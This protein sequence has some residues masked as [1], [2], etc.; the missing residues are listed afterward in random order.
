M[1]NVVTAQDLPTDNPYKTK[2][3]ATNYPLWTDEIRWENVYDIHDFEVAGETSW[4][5]A[6]VVAMDSISAQN[7]GVIYFSEG[8][9]N[10][11]EN[12]KIPDG[13]VIRGKLPDNNDAKQDNFAPSTRFVF[14]KYEPTFTGEG[15][16]NSTAFKSITNSGRENI[17]L[18]YLDINRGRI[19]FGGDHNILIF[20]I[21]QNNIAQPQTDIP[22]KYDYMHGWQRF[23][24]RHC[25]NVGLYVSKNGSMVNC[26]INDLE[27]NTVHPIEDDSYD[28]PGYIAGCEFTYNGDGLPNGTK[29]CDTSAAI[30]DGSMA[31]FDYLAHYAISVKGYTIDP[32]SLELPIN[33]NI[34]VIDN[35]IYNTMRVGI[36][37]EAI[38]LTVRGNVRKDKEDK[39]VFLHP[40]GYKLND[41]N[42]ATFENRAMNFGGENIIIED[43]D[44]E[45]YR[46]SLMYTGYGSIDG[47]GIMMQTQDKWGE[48]MNGVYIRNNKVNSYIGF[49]DLK[50][51][52]RNVYIE[53][54]DLQDKGS[55]M[56]FKKEVRYR[57][58]DIYIRN[59]T[60]S[61]SINVGYRQSAT[62]YQTTGQNIYI[63]DNS[64][65]GNINYPCQAIV[66][67]NTGFTDD[68][69]CNGGLNEQ[70][71]LKPYYGAIEQRTDAIISIEFSENIKEG[72]MTGVTIKDDNENPVNVSSLLVSGKTLNIVHTGLDSPN[73][74]YTITVPQGVVLATSDDTPNYEISWW[75]KTTAKPYLL[76]KFPSDSTKSATPDQFIACTFAQNVTE[77]DFSGIKIINEE[78]EEVKN[79]QA[80]LTDSTLIINHDLLTK[81]NHYYTIIIPA[82]SVENLAGFKN[83]TIKWT[84]K[85][86]VATGFDD[87][88]FVSNNDIILYPVPTND[89]LTI[90]AENLTNSTVSIIDLTGKLI[91]QG[92]AQTS[93]L[94]IEVQYLNPGIYA[95]KIEKKNQ[96]SILKFI[97]K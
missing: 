34:E 65:T 26:R 48:Q 59:N 21:R 46:H 62:E 38:G 70:F 86:I 77:S 91:Y 84:I 42:S 60:H 33:Q 24:Y 97:K 74:K 85:T 94:Q 44:F 40:V 30:T 12:V 82:N 9:Y 64:G 36:F 39:R 72:S 37:A 16:P 8:T 78:N 25:R 67:N 32:A 5:S 10:F 6:L 92:K 66:E 31:R 54:N 83:D 13:I 47:E 43:N 4:D 96:I 14:P 76:S 87:N 7:G 95:C 61:K 20:G 45:V 69:V 80:T 35:W 23:S 41:N 15:T 2:Y 75:F 56:F 81:T 51:D 11:S 52:I 90:E 93:K 68:I 1:A 29:N 73:T 17:G 55:I 18:V 27:N 22:S 71:F 88:S 53:N 63:Q 50:F 58:D 19:S 49:Y 28:Q 3:G 89:C 79:V 57:L